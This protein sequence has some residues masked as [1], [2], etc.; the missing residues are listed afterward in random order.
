MSKTKKYLQDFAGNLAQAMVKNG[1]NWDCIFKR[2]SMPVNA[3]TN[4]RYKGFLH[5]INNG[6]V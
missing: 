6:L 2:N 4:K 1:T 5:L 3:S